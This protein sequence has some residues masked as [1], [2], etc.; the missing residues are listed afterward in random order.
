I[1]ARFSPCRRYIPELLERGDLILV[2]AERLLGLCEFLPIDGIAGVG[3]KEIAKSFGGLLPSLRLHVCGHITGELLGFRNR[4]GRTARD[5]GSRPAKQQQNRKR[6]GYSME[7][8][9]FRPESRY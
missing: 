4:C 9:F 7:S 2:V 3:S 5:N 6:N 1:S 8:H